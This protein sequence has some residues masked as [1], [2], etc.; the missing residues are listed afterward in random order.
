MLCNMGWFIYFSVLP[1][2]LTPNPLGFG[3]RLLGTKVKMIELKKKIKEL[4]GKL[5]NK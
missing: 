2:H 4:E 5:G 3:I 1:I